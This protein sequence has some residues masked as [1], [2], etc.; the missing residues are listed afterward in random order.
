MAFPKRAKI[1]EYLIGIYDMFVMLLS[2]G[3]ASNNDP[4]PSLLDVMKILGAFHTNLAL[5]IC[6]F[7]L[8]EKTGRV[9]QQQSSSEDVLLI[10]P[11]EQDRRLLPTKLTPAASA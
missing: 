3:L 9:L 11:S 10:I 2:R 8:G 4:L 5:R 6:L 7:S 1:H